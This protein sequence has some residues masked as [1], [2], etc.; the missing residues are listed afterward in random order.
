MSFLMYWLRFAT[1][2]IIMGANAIHRTVTL[3]T[4][5]PVGLCESRMDPVPSIPVPYDWMTNRWPIRLHQEHNAC[6]SSHNLS[7][8]LFWTLCRCSNDRYVQT[9]G[10]ACADSHNQEHN[11]RRMAVVPVHFPKRRLYNV[12]RPWYSLVQGPV[13]PLHS[14]DPVRGCRPDFSNTR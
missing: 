3:V 2:T 14:W 7:I 1:V 8:R 5:S 13:E 12:R 9:I 4:Q 10:C 11:H 6:A